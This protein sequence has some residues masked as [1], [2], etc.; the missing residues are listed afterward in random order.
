MADAA[1]R[2]ASAQRVQVAATVS[3]QDH[4]ADHV[5]AL[6]KQRTDRERNQ[7]TVI[8]FRQ[9]NLCGSDWLMTRVALESGLKQPS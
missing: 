3:A 1:M 7:E 9:E 6:L 8:R 5:A 4:R 2:R